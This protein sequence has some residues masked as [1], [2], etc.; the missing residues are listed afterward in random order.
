MNDV[1]SI[2]LVGRLTRDVELKYTSGGMAIAE[3]AIAVNRSVK[4]AEG[5]K[6]SP[7]FFDFSIFGKTAESLKPYLL[8]GKQIA[9]TGFL[10]Q[11]SWNDRDTGAK[12]SRV[13][14]CATEIEL[15]GNKNDGSNGSGGSESSGAQNDGYGYSAPADGYQEDIPF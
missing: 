10:K 7:S 2:A 3:G 12:R 9:L 1:N 11:E 8:K 15:L 5:Y 13:R 14:I 6:N 4:T